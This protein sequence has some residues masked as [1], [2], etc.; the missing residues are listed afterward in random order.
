M[1]VRVMDSTAITLCMDNHLP[2][3]VLDLW[4]EG[5]LVQALQGTSVGTLIC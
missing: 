3:V 4:D 1:Q 5:S 2:L